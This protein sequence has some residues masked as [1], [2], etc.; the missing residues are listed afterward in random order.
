MSIKDLPI[1]RKLMAIT[2]VTSGVVLLLT[3]AAFFAYEF[4]TFRQ[5]TVKLLSTRG[6]IIAQKTLKDMTFTP[7]HQIARNAVAFQG[8]A[9]P[10]PG[11]YLI[12]FV[13]NRDDVLASFPMWVQH[14]PSSK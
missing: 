1:K 2:L 9:W 3:C 13:A 5:T 10:S 11:H 4:L 8:F 7:T 12:K 14:A 6:E